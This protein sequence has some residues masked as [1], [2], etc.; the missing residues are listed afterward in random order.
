MSVTGVDLPVVAAA[1][2]THSLTHSLTVAIVLYAHLLQV[3]ELVPYP[4]GG[5]KQNKHIKQKISIF[6]RIADVAYLLQCSGFH[7]S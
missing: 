4:T 5:M 7:A 6:Q 2:T 3:A 1:K